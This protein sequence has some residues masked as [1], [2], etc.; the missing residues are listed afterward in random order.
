MQLVLLSAPVYDALTI[1][2]RA[3][4]APPGMAYAVP[5]LWWLVLRA[6][7]RPAVVLISPQA[8]EVSLSD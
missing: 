5:F 8:V 3:L 4:V 2:H 6:L 7:A 1:F